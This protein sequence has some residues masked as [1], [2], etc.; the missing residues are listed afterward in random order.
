MKNWIFFLLTASSDLIEQ[1]EY[2]QAIE[3]LLQEKK[4]TISLPIAYLRD[5]QEEE[6]FVSYL[7]FL[8]RVEKSPLKAPS[9]AERARYSELFTLYLANDPKVDDELKGLPKDYYMCQ[10]LRASRLANQRKYEEFF[11]VFAES[12]I[13][14]P[15]SHMALKTEGVIE[16]LIFQRTK[17]PEAKEHWRKKALQSFRDSLQKNP[18][19]VSL[20]KMIIYTASDNEKKEVISFVL[21]QIIEHNVEINRREIPFYINNALLVD[22][23]LLAESLIDKAKTWYEYSR[24]LDEMD[25]QVTQ[26]KGSLHDSSH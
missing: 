1:R 6:A 17:K 26:Y 24:I 2:K 23:V 16:S 9:D 18:H 13:R 11:T 4:P 15:D 3:Q 25:Q 10:F 12:Y 8:K 7:D 5:Q 21:T 14:Y 20:H 22:E 19:D